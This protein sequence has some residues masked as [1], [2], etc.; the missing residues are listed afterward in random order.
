MAMRDAQGSSGSPSSPSL[1]QREAKSLDN[2]VYGAIS[3]SSSSAYKLPTNSTALLA[4]QS[5]V[6]SSDSAY[7]QI[8]ETEG[9]IQPYAASQGKGPLDYIN[10]PAL[11]HLKSTAQFVKSEIEHHGTD[12]GRALQNIGVLKQLSNADKGSNGEILKE[13]TPSLHQQYTSELQR[14]QSERADRGTAQSAANAAY[15]SASLDQKD[16]AIHGLL[17]SPVFA[18]APEALRVLNNA[19]MDIIDRHHAK[20][21]A[22]YDRQAPSQEILRNKYLQ[23]DALVA[24]FGPDNRDSAFSKALAAKA[25]DPESAET[26]V[27]TF[28]TQLQE[29]SLKLILDPQGLQT[30]TQDFSAQVDAIAQG[31]LQAPK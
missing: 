23:R 20:G 14:L 10:D 31:L 26:L 11:S 2:P 13:L 25:L 1:Q 7:G 8:D 24:Q 27:D 16:L 28:K 29:A 18:Q 15:Q 17:K 9:D 6:I 22:N 12:A 4:S 3:D 5:P 19:Y 30:S 21:N